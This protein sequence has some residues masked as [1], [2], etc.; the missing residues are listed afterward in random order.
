[1]RLLSP[2]DDELPESS[3]WNWSVSSESSSSRVSGELAVPESRTMPLV[4]E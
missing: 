1:M 4:F 2:S 3:C